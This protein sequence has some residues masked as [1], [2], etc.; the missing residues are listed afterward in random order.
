MTI[1]RITRRR[2]LQKLFAA[3]VAGPFVFRAH[4]A[5][6]SETVY[7]ASVGGAG[8]AASDIRS[9]TAS[10][11]LKLVAVAD[12]DL[13][14]TRAVKRDFPDVRVYQDWRELLDKEKNL[15]SVNVSTPDH[16][17][18]PATMRAMQ[19]GLHVYTQK[20][21]TQTIYEARQLTRVAAEK[22]L[23]TQ[24]GIQ[25]HSHAVHR[26][27]VRLIQGGAIGKVK[28]VHSWSGKGWGD[29]SPRPDRADPV[30]EGF[31]WDFWLG[32][33]AER[34]FIGNG[35]Y[36]PSNWRKRLDFGTGTFGDMGC[37]I[38]DPVF[39]SLALTA[40]KSVRSEGDAPAGDNWGLDVLVK[41]V[42]PGTKYTTDPLPVT[43]YNGN[44]RPPAAVQELVPAPAVGQARGGRRRADRPPDRLKDQGS[45]YVGTE[46]VLYSPYVDPPVLLPQE[47]FREYAVP[48][49]GAED[50]YLQFVEACRGNG[51]TST[52]FAY[53]GPLTE[54]VLLGCLATRF[55]LTTLA[56]DAAAVRVTNEERANRF[57]RKTYRK[58]WEVDG[59]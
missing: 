36:H 35:Y 43:W 30:P 33:A 17:H 2:A 5:A 4:A 27:V 32:V 37:H 22:Q 41:Y 38:L 39:G 1:T 28:E 23:V 47:K 44:R 13:G 50:H 24:M 16:T 52:P 25:I 18:A 31:N 40:A 21:L 59:L 19:R 34:P 12:V 46:G 54:M 11:N 14:R 57:V 53:S 3:G 29:R 51:Q 8:M 9:L 56:W 55:P 7:H 42:F 15:T 10:K 6:P 48:N 58:G 26:T 49:P 45:I 20:P